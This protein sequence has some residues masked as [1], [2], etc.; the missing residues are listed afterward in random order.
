M[1][2]APGAKAK[3]ISYSTTHAETLAAISGLEAASL[4]AV[5]LAELL[6]VPKL[7]MQS[8]TSAQEFGVKQ[9]LVECYGDCPD[10]YELCTGNKV[11]CQDKS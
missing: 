6:Y 5:R 2:Y 11:L 8:L 7:T 1:L 9:L 10:L 4:L 3:R